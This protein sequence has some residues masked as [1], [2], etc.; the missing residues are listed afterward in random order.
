V[1]VS[2]LRRSYPARHPVILYKASQFSI[3]DAIIRKTTLARLPREVVPA[4]A[5][6]Y[7]P[8]RPPAAPDA[9]V[10]RWMHDK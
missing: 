8:P 7:V 1:L 4:M 5:T 10:L 6:M 2:R 3:C 9:R